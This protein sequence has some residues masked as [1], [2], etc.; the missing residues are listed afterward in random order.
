[1]LQIMIKSY[2]F[3]T[4]CEVILMCQLILN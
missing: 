1:M 4:I 2:V 3:G